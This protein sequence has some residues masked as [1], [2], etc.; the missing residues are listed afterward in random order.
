M[1]ASLWMFSTSLISI[2]CC[3]MCREYKYSDETFFSYVCTIFS[4]NQWESYF[5][6]YNYEVCNI[7]NNE[8]LLFVSGDG[9]SILLMTMVCTC[10]LNLRGLK[11]IGSSSDKLFLAE[12]IHNYNILNHRKIKFNVLLFHNQ[13]LWLPLK[14]MYNLYR[15]NIKVIFIHSQNKWS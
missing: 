4:A 9:Q 7:L 14:F 11:S 3:Y 15:T 6:C 13:Y 12:A 2:V 8:I 1:V 5:L 10:L